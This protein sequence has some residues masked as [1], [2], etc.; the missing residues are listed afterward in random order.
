MKES[1]FLSFVKAVSWRA[2]GTSATWVVAF[3]L[4]GDAVLSTKFSLIECVSKIALYYLHERIWQTNLKLWSE[5]LW[6][7]N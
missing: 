2:F 5:K 1:N 7:T 3:F 4:T 6:K